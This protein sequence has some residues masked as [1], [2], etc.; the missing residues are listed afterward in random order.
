MTILTPN[1]QKELYDRFGN[2]D[3]ETFRKYCIQTIERAQKPDRAM[4]A[5]M[6]RMTKN[7]LLFSTNNFIMS[8]LGFKVI[9]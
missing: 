2:N 7:Q 4:I 6:N 3:I 9:C 5:K 8:G 1:D